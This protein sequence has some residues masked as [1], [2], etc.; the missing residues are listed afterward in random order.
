MGSRSDPVTDRLAERPGAGWARGATRCG[1]AIRRSS[2][3]AQGCRLRT[4]FGKDLK[5]LSVAGAV[6]RSADSTHRADHVVTPG[7]PDEFA[8]T[9]LGSPAR[10]G[11]PPDTM[12]P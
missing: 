3:V 8:A 10:S 5:K 7:R 11:R 1:I 9:K 12:E 6:A 4:F 2:R